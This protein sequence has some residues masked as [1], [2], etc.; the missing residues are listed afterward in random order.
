MSDA[1]LRVVGCFPSRVYSC[2]SYLHSL[3]TMQRD[4]EE[5][6][7]VLS[8]ATLKPRTAVRSPG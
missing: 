8:E 5:R 2:A 3:S 1:F 6:G 4:P 7:K